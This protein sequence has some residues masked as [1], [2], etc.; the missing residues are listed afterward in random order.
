MFGADESSIASHNSLS[1][2]VPRACHEIFQ[3]IKDRSL[4]CG[5]DTQVSV[6]YVEIYGNQ[7]CTDS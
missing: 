7:V 3:A 4:N 5:I 1:G 6:S 2:I